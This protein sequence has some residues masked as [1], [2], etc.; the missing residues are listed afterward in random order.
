M[1]QEIDSFHALLKPGPLYVD[2]ETKNLLGWKEVPGTEFEV[3]IVQT[4]IYESVDQ[5]L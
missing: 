2:R 1:P 5:T 4:P 3:L